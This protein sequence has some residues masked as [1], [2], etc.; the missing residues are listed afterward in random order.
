[1]KVP[2]H[3]N[4]PRPLLNDMPGYDCDSQPAHLVVLGCMDLEMEEVLEL[5][6]IPLR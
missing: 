4:P 6:G 2:V 3:P 5:T 1:M